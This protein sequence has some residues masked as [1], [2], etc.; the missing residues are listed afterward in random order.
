[1]IVKMLGKEVNGMEGARLKELRKALGLTLEQFGKKIGLTKSALSLIENGRN[2][3]TARTRLAICREY[4]VS[5]KWLESGEG[6]M[7]VADTQ[8]YRQLRNEVDRVLSDESEAFKAALVDVVLRL[9]SEQIEVLKEYAARYYG[10]T[11]GGEEG[12]AG[13][14]P[15]DAAGPFADLAAASPDPEDQAAAATFASAAAASPDP[16]DQGAAATF[17]SAAAVGTDPSFAPAAASPAFDREGQT[18]VKPRRAEADRAPAA[19]WQQ[20]AAETGRTAA[21]DTDPDEPVG[22]SGKDV[23]EIERMVSD[24]RAQL[25]AEKKAAAASAASHVHGSKK[26]A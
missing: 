19:K 6:E 10:V 4:G 14:E 12:Q 21:A 7:F 26:E 20:N 11:V 25:I 1:M 17:A 9:N 15:E 24:Y 8:A 22:L 2:E 3:M 18:E 5:E 16:E 13:E 23:V